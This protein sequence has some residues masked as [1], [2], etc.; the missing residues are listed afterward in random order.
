MILG[1]KCIRPNFRTDPIDNPSWLSLW[2]QN[3]VNM[4]NV[5]FIC[6]DLD[7][8]FLF[9]NRRKNHSRPLAGT[10]QKGAGQ[11]VRVEALRHNDNSA[12]QLVVRARCQS[13]AVPLVDRFTL[14]FRKRVDRLKRIID[15]DDVAARSVLRRSMSPDGSRSV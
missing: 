8:L 7:L 3:F 2:V 5:V 13:I 9:G 14:A 11:I 1:R 10:T 15:N 6:T 12:V 4:A